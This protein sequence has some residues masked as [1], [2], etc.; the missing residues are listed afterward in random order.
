M[1]RAENLVTLLELGYVP[2]NGFYLASQVSAGPRGSGDRWFAQP[3][4]YAK[5]KRRTSHD[6]PVKWVDRSRADSEQD[7]VVLGNG[8][9]EVH[10]LD[11]IR[12]SVSGI[13]GGFHVRI[14]AALACSFH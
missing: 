6:A 10:D 3:E 12:R 4:N 1:A 5:G 7:F 13:D 8:L 9:L 14:P 11:N 2:A